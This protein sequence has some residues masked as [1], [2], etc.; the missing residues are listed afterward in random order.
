LR[1]C[2]SGSADGSQGVLGLPLNCSLIGFLEHV[3]RRVGPVSPAVQSLVEVGDQAHGEHVGCVSLREF[4]FAG[5][6]RAKSL[7]GVGRV[8]P[9]AGDRL[10]QLSDAGLVSEEH[11]ERGLGFDLRGLTWLGEPVAQRLLPSRG[12][13]IDGAR[14]SPGRRLLG[15]GPAKRNEPLGLL[16]NGPFGSREKPSEAPLRLP[17]QLVCGPGAEREQSEDG[18]GGVGGLCLPH[19]VDDTA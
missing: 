16:V 2:R 4:V 19:T 15:P 14:S 8:I 18:V 9:D 5:R 13:A 6:H 11:L 7:E 3:D 10:P 17:G 1:E 12:D